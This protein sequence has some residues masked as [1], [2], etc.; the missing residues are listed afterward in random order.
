MY[1]CIFQCIF[2]PPLNKPPPVTTFVTTFVSPFVSP[3]VFTDPP[4][5][6]LNNFN[7]LFIPYNIIINNNGH[8]NG[9][10]WVFFFVFIF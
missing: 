9:Y 7:K 5:T 10:G 8:S 2:L 1:L 4:L 6:G 3:S